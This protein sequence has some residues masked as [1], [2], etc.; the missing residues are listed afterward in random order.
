[1]SIIR[2]YSVYQLVGHEDRSNYNGILNLWTSGELAAGIIISCLPVLPRFVR[3]YAPRIR[4]VISSNV[5]MHYMSPV[6]EVRIQTRPNE[7]NNWHELR[8]QVSDNDPAVVQHGPAQSECSTE[9]VSNQ[10]SFVPDP[11][12]LSRGEP[13]LRQ[14]LMI[15]QIE[16]QTEAH[17]MA[18][19]A[20]PPNLERRQLGW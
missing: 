4:S 3:T 14:I 8:T 6:L 9:N 13:S 17:N 15:T 16:A 20:I 10:S 11:V 1:M 5:K 19:R 18:D 2:T 12:T 7:L